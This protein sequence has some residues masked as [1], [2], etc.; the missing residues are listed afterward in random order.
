MSK[1]KEEI[2]NTYGRLTVIS[3]EMNSALGQAKW[4]C[5]CRCGKTLIVHGAD[6]RNGHTQ[7]CG[8]LV[9]DVVTQRNWKGGRRVCTRGYI[10]I[11]LGKGKRRREHILIAEE[12]LG[13]SLK[14]GEMVHHINGDKADNRNRNLLICDRSYHQWLHHKMSYLYQ[15]EH[16]QET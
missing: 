2:G 14:K 3:R 16:F 12:I 4:R 8:C 7:S 11:Y 13:R 6:L 1:L 10:T 15:Q 9:S 5:I